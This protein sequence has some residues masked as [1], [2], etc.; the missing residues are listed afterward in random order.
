MMGGLPPDRMVGELLGLLGFLSV[1][2]VSTEI[3]FGY[4]SE[5]GVVAG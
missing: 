5:I 4:E 2:C 1:L 3:D